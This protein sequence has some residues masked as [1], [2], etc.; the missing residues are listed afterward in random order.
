[1]GRKDMKSRR[2]VMGHSL[3]RSLVRSH[4]SLIR[5]LRTARFA[6]ALA[7]SLAPEKEGRGNVFEMNASISYRFNPLCVHDSMYLGDGHKCD[8]VACVG[9]STHHGEEPPKRD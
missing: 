9:G 1:M 3:F 8:E 7:H 2:R 5:E 6:H 4:R